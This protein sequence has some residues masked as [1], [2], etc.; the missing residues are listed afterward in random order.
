MF[1]PQPR[2]PL[3]T[4]AQFGSKPYARIRI[5]NTGD[6]VLVPL[7]WF[8]RVQLARRATAKT[9]LNCFYSANLAEKPNFRLRIWQH[10]FSPGY[11]CQYA[12]N[13]LE[14]FEGETRSDEWCSRPH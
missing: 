7:H 12:V 8:H 6:E 2:P 3:H 1:D 11:G 9:V 13:V 5:C 14:I 10:G 4:A